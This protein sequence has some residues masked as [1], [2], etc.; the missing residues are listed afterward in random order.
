MFDLQ[1]TIRICKKEYIY[2]LKTEYFSKYVINYKKKDSLL[3]LTLFNTQKNIFWTK[4]KYFI[5]LLLLPLT[6]S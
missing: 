1:H 2:L 6:S 4:R 5:A 3:S